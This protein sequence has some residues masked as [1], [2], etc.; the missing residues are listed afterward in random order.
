MLEE[1][2]GKRLAKLGLKAIILEDVPE[3]SEC[4]VLV[5]K[6][7]FAELVDM[8]ELAG[9]YSGTAIEKLKKI[10]GEKTR[11]FKYRTCRRI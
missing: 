7:D 10:Y 5:V 8:P 3:D 1:S 4:M 6:K 2:P 9:V 11:N